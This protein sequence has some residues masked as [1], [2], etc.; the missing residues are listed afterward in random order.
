MKLQDK[1]VPLIIIK[2]SLLGEARQSNIF[3]ESR[4]QFACRWR[5]QGGIVASGLTQFADRSFSLH[6]PRSWGLSCY[7]NLFAKGTI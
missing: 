5:F 2:N 1:T 4:Q 7:G 3:Y 6:L